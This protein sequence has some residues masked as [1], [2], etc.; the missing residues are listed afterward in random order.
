MQVTDLITTKFN[1]IQSAQ[2]VYET[3]LKK[4]MNEMK[5]DVLSLK[6]T[7]KQGDKTRHRNN[8]MKDYSKK[9]NVYVKKL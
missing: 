7:V 1:E 8:T 3:E 9:T 4:E 2:K 5:E 6:S